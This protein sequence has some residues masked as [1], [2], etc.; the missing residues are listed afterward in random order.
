MKKYLADYA[1][2]FSIAGIVIFLDQWTKQLVRTNLM[3]SEIYRPDL[4]ITQ[5]ARIVNWSNTGAAF[6]L[7]QNMNIV[8][9]VLSFIVS[10]AIIY[11]FPQVS[12]HDWTLRLALSLQLGGAIGNLIDRLTQGYVTDFI[13]IGAFPV[14]NV[15]DSSISV[16]V[17]VLVLGMW[18]HEQR[19]KTQPEPIP[20]SPEEPPKETQ[21]E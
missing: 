12:W 1:W 9:T 6:G 2:L 15:A 20:A 13:S 3:H 14:F 21:G 8:F 16:G 19:E 17:A 18:L 11:Y 5:Y 4:W 10:A 7:F